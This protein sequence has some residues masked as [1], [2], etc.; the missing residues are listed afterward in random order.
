M[1][2]SSIREAGPGRR[3]GGSDQSGRRASLEPDQPVEYERDD[4]AEDIDYLAS[5]PQKTTA[6]EIGMSERRW[7]GY[8]TG[9]DQAARLDS[10]AHSRSGTSTQIGSGIE[11]N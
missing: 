7:G 5:F 6:A 8:R 4:L 2:E 9:K 10:G 3:G 1:F 11:R